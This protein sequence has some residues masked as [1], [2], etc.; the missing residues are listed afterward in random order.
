M[1][2]PSEIQL[3]LFA[4]GD[5]AG[6]WERW[7]VGRH[8]S[9]CAVC[10][11]EVENLRAGSGQ[12]QALAA[13]LP[14][15]LNWNRLAEEMTGNIRVGLAAG[16]AIAR[17]DRP[18]VSRPLRL[19]WNAALVLGCATAVFVAAFWMSLPQQQ[20]EH[21][22]A[23]LKRIRTERIGK[24]VEHRAAT[25]DEVVLEASSS[26]LQVKENGGAMS[27]L[28]PHSDGVTVSVSMHGSAAVRYV[29]ADTGQVTTN[30]VYYA[31]Q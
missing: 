16:E 4:G 3:A 18:A 1:K 23:A 20:A 28:H 2:H 5:L 31:E 8:V 30:K 27:L 17:F 7:R 15:D 11:S 21:L 6:R 29:D 9:H 26:N 19:G 22:A 10:R 25:A 12:L 13:E 14:K 24:L